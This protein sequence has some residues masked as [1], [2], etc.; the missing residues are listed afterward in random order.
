MKI[1]LIGSGNVAWHFGKAFYNVGHSI[2]F[3]Y[4]RNK[5][6]SVELASLFNGCHLLSAGEV[7]NSTSDI[8]I[9]AVTDS[10][11]QEILSSIDFPK[12]SIVVHTSGSVSVDVLKGYSNNGVLYALQT[13]TKNKEIALSDVPFG[14][15]A[16]NESTFNTLKSLASSISNNVSSMNSEQRKVLH[17]AAVFA[18]NFTNY[19]FSISEKILKKEH[20]NFSLLESLVKETVQKAFEIGP[21]AA[22]TG[23]AKRGDRKI[24]LDHLDY[25]KN[26]PDLSTLYTLL[27]EG[28]QKK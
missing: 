20:S 3:V 12:D 16:S 27:S 26:E 13:F 9:I 2:Q 15:E 5:E 8:Y 1:T 14:I 18:C 22:Q 21:K 4:G 23:P 11:I 25:L 17:I 7:I 6:S 10:S 28:I 24:M 19:L